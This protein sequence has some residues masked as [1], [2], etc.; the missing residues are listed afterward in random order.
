MKSPRKIARRFEVL[1]RALRLPIAEGIE[2]LGSRTSRA[3]FFQA[4]CLLHRSL[5]LRQ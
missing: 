2:K 3:P 4:F 1:V 5:T